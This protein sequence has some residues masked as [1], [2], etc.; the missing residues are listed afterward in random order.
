[1]SNTLFKKE[2]IEQ[3]RQNQYI[4]SVS[5]KGITYTD[6]FR[7]IFIS[8][9][10]KGHLPREIFEQH[11]FDLSIIGM[12]RVASAGKRWRAAY[13]KEGILGLKDQRGQ[14]SGRPRKRELT[15]EEEL[16]RTKAELEFA[17]AEIELLKKLKQLRIIQK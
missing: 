4:K 9:N 5:E 1:M 8:L 7:E 15:L 2:E 16:I 6:E 17:K 12:E 3:L 14:T 11:G 13:R 10:Q